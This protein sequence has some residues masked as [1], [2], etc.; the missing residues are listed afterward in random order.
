MSFVA[1]PMVA[2]KAG[3]GGGFGVG[4][5]FGMG[6]GTAP[7]GPAEG[8]VRFADPMSAQSAV[9][10]TGFALGGSAITVVLDPTSTDGTKVNVT[11]FGP[12]V[13]WQELKDFFKQCGA[14]VFA[15]VKGKSSGKGWGK[16]Q[17]SGPS[18]GEVRMST[19]EEALLATQLLNGSQLGGGTIQVTMH[20]NSTDNT[21][22]AV[23]GIPAGV[24]WQDLKDFFKQCGTV[25]HA[26]TA[27]AGHGGGGQHPG[28]GEVR[29]D[30]PQQAMLALQALNGSQLGSSQIFL[31]LDPGST[32]MSKLTVTGIAPGIGWQELKDHFSSMGVVAFADVHKGG[33]K[34]GGGKGKGGFSPFGGAKGGAWKGGGGGGV[35]FSPYG[36][37]KG[38]GGKSAPSGPSFPRV[39]GALTGTVRFETPAAAQMALAQMNGAFIGAGQITVDSDWNSQDGTKLWLGGIPP[40]TDPQELKDAFAQFGPIA[41]ANVNKGKGKGMV[42]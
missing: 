21:K 27:Q 6:G 23:T 37:A 25:M 9:A 8:E 40:E 30:D 19:A 17:G 35:G 3:F 11:G 7:S 41:F 12:Q 31:A 34:W 36:G 14:V 4:G 42:N 22:L 38:G 2:G 29:Y 32:D 24:S 5:G 16:G 20:A 13:M 26:D 39:P 15:D 33:G 1:T 10:M 18:I 28:T